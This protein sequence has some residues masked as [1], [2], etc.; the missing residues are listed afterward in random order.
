MHDSLTSAERLE[1]QQLLQLNFWDRQAATA[2]AKKEQTSSEIK[3]HVELPE[4]W[5]LTR[6]IDLHPWQKQCVDV[7]FQACRRGVLKVVTGAGKTVLALAIAERLQQTEAHDLRVA[8][9]VPT[10]VLLDQWK[11]EILS[12]SNLP[13]EAIGLLGGGADE[14]FNVDTRILIC[15]LNSAARK[16]PDLVRSAGVGSSMLLIVDE[17]HRA[18]AKEMRRIFETERAF[19]LGLS[20]TPERESDF[21]EQEGDLTEPVEEEN[22]NPVSFDETVTGIPAD[23]AHKDLV[24]LVNGLKEAEGLGA[25]GGFGINEHFQVVARMAAPAGYKQNSIYVIDTSSGMVKTY[26]E[27]TT[28]QGGA[29]TPKAELEEGDPWTGPRCGATYRFAAPG[30]KKPPTHNLD[31]IW[32]EVEGQIDLLSTHLRSGSYPPTAGPLAAFLAALRRQLPLAA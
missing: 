22:Y 31:E 9:V 15:V 13:P 28:F 11:H 6:G 12:R 29:I 14:T 5:S 16:L 17:C 7:W 1:L 24:E 26:T 4:R 23:F 8:I 20:A 19:S 30:N 32:T 21:A 2:D 18:G 27:T 25:G 3:N 10:V